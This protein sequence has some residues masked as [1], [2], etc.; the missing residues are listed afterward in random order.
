MAKKIQGRKRHILVG[1]L[2]LIMIV[3]VTAASAQERDGAKSPFNSL[4]GSCKKIRRIWV[5]KRTFA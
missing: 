5:D 2:G 4:T 3:M 1:T